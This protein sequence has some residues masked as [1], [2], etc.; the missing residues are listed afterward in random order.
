VQASGVTKFV[1]YG[2][3]YFGTVAAQ[4]TVFHPEHVAGLVLWNIETGGP[5][6]QAPIIYELSSRSWDLFLETYARTFNSYEDPQA[7]ITRLGAAVDQSDFG[8]GGDPSWDV[9]ATLRSVSSPTLVIA[10]RG[11]GLDLEERG[12]QVAGLI[13]GA[14]LLLFDDVAGGRYTSDGSTPALVGA[15]ES[16][17]ATLPDAGATAAYDVRESPDKEVLSSR[18]AEV[19]RLLAAGRSN[20]QIADQ[21]V[22]SLNTVRRHV[23]NIFDKTGVSNRAQA[24]VYAKDHGLA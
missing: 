24:A 21:L 22:I 18:E 2:G 17:V 23:S 8:R 1:L 13:P 14:R 5:L 20:Q 19:L 7:A 10:R 16:F 4:Y 3:Y 6:L 11:S 12:K 15:I 9:P